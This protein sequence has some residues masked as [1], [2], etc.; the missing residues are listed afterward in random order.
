[1]WEESAD[2]E[3]LSISPRYTKVHRGEV[4]A[5]SR[6]TATALPSLTS[7]L[8]PASASVALPELPLA[9][10]LIR[11]Q[12]RGAFERSPPMGGRARRTQ[13]DADGPDT[14]ILLVKQACVKSEVQCMMKRNQTPATIGLTS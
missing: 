14:K 8:P 10:F 13:T 3:T 1:M 12:E 7:S 11:E 9:R 5:C 4:E 2:A 6:T